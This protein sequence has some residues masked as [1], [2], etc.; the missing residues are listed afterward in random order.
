VNGQ[1][2]KAWLYQDALRPLSEVDAE[3]TFT[4]FVYTNADSAPD[5]ILRSGKPYR[6]V[7]D[8]VGSVRLVVNAETGEIVQQI[9]YDEFEQVLQDT[10]P[11]FQPFGFT[12]GLYDA[13]MGLVRF[14]ARDYDASTG[15]W[16]S[17]D[18]LGF[19]AHG[20]NL[21]AYALSDP[22]NH[23]ESDGTRCLCVY[24]QRAIPAPL[25]RDRR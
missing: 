14:G 9:D 19:A 12:G 6:I 11:G 5:F 2:S 22:I 21:F 24:N 10:N 15:R 13:Q 3:G 7:K 8:H 16:I 4:H 20:T 1:F 25:G 17:K 18:P 23:I